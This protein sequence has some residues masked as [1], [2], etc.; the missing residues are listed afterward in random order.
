MRWVG[1]E[2]ESTELVPGKSEV[3]KEGRGGGGGGGG[4]GGE[5]TKGGLDRGDKGGKM[6]VKC[7]DPFLM[8]K[9]LS[10]STELRLL[11]DFRWL[12]ARCS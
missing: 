10:D 5:V 7:K 6:E 2:I 3:T 11:F 8:K 4:G 9:S 1:G 12:D